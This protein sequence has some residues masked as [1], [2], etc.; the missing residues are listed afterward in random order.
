MRTGVVEST[1][2]LVEDVQVVL[3]VLKGT[4]L[5]ELVRVPQVSPLLRDLGPFPFP[6][7]TRQ[8]G[9]T[10]T[11][12]AIRAI[13]LEQPWLDPAAENLDWRVCTTPKSWP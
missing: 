13:P 1:P 10:R 2:H 4:V 7:A 11:V 6:F 12:A 5:G 8:S 3:D 9:E